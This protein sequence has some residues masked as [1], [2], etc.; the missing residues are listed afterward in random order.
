MR[1][2][3]AILLVFV[4]DDLG[5]NP[6]LHSYLSGLILVTIVVVLAP[7][8]PWAEIARSIRSRRSSASPE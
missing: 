2:T 6:L 4:L 3:V 7:M 1:G 5:D 8:P